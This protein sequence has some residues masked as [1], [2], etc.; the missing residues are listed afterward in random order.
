[1]EHLKKNSNEPQLDPKEVQ[2]QEKRVIAITTECQEL[3]K[4][5][6]EFDQYSQTDPDYIGSPFRKKVLE[7]LSASEQFINS[8]TGE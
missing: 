5:L 3:I 2:G 7:K 4:I 8:V 6:T 1:M